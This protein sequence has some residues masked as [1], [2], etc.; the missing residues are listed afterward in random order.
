M[1]QIVKETIETKVNRETDKI[2]M[3]RL[4]KIAS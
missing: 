4:Y 3:G 2:I 1:V